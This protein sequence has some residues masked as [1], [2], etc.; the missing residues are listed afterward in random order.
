VQDIINGIEIPSRLIAFMRK[1]HCSRQKEHRRSRPLIIVDEPLTA[2]LSFTGTYRLMRFS[3]QFLL[4]ITITGAKT[5]CKTKR[6]LLALRLFQDVLEEIA[7]DDAHI[8]NSDC[9]INFIACVYKLYRKGESVRKLHR[10]V[11]RVR[12]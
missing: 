6:V 11:H 9:D 8:C 1:D 4:S 7:V 12:R 2:L 10:D 3:F 5:R